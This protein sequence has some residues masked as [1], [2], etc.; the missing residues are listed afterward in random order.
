MAPSSTTTLDLTPEHSLAH[1]GSGESDACFAAGMRNGEGGEEREVAEL[2]LEILEALVLA[3]SRRAEVLDAVGQAEDFDT[4]ELAVRDLLDV[5][6]IGARAVLDAQLR[7]FTARERANL[8]SRRDELRL[9]LEQ[10]E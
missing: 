5:G 7:R 9:H 1:L 4:A 10:L 6:E 8:T 2:R 3:S